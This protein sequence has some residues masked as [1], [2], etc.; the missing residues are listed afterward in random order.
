MEK[1]NYEHR[2]MVLLVLPCWH[3]GIPK[4]EVPRWGSMF[5]TNQ[6]SSRTA[7]R[8][9][10]NFICSGVVALSFPWA[11]PPFV[12]GQKGQITPYSTCPHTV[13][14]IPVFLF[15]LSFYGSDYIFPIL[16]IT[17]KLFPVWNLSF[18][19]DYH[20]WVYCL[21]RRGATAPPHP[22]PSLSHARGY[23]SS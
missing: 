8:T 2:V 13:L 12:W 18:E 4:P 6:L 11:F 15:S 20:P 17:P 10:L 9:L 19:R 1:R 5:A 23:V 3:E 14:P 21:S 7:S 22:F 16:W